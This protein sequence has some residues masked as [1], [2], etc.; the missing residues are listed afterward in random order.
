MDEKV[1]VFEL[2]T[3]GKG[4]PFSR[5]KFY[6]LQIERYH[7][8]GKPLIA[9]EIVNIFLFNEYGELLVQKRSRAKRHNPNLQDKSIGGHVKW[10]DTPDYTVMVETIQELKVPSIV[11]RTNSNFTKT[12]NLL[13][14]YLDTVAIIKQIDTQI[15]KLPKIIDN[16]KIVIGN[17]VNIYLAHVQQGGY[18]TGLRLK[19]KSYY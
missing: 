17:K 3:S 2:K 10:G 18:L 19:K 4:K 7:K 5:K 13:R 9:V 15:L 11:L 14:D 6:D 8:N 1:V 12:Y 16:K